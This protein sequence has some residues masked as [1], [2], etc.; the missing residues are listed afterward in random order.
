MALSFRLS[1]KKI[2]QKHHMDKGDLVMF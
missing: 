2:I 1:K